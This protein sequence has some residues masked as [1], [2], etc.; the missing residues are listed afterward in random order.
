MYVESKLHVTLL[1]PGHPVIIFCIIF[2]ILVCSACARVFCLLH[3]R[4]THTPDMG[5][6]RRANWLK[7]FFVFMNECVLLLLFFF[8]HFSFSLSLWSNCVINSLIYVFIAHSHSISHS[9][10]GR[11]ICNWACV[12]NTEHTTRRK[13]FWIRTPATQRKIECVCV[14]FYCI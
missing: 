6:G 9:K 3:S 14:F 5:S 8:H 2:F 12:L 13:R 4:Y 10:S 11:T 1:S 7:L